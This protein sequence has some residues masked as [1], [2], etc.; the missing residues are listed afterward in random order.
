[1]TTTQPMRKHVPVRSCAVC[2][3]SADKRKL[4]RVVRTGDGIHVD[5]TGKMNGRGAYLCDTPSCWEKAIQSGVL[6]QALR[7]KL[8]DDDRERLQQARPQS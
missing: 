5:A 6:E 7:T 1:M 8:T 2:R 4:T 3:A